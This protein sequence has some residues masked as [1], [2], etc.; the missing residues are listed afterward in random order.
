MGLWLQTVG[1]LEGAGGSQIL[2]DRELVGKLYMWREGLKRAVFLI[3]L[4]L[5]PTWGSVTPQSP[6]VPAQESRNEEPL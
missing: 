6:H 5:D 1:C 4:C 3:S 2:L